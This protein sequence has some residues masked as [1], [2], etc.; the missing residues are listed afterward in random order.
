MI[1]YTGYSSPIAGR[2]ETLASSVHSVSYESS[3]DLVIVEARLLDLIEL[4]VGPADSV[5]KI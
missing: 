3:L 2:I 4:V 5:F 1:L